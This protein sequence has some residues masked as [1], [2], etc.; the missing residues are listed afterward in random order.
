M[1][2]AI[3]AGNTNT[4]FAVYDQNDEL[5]KVWRLATSSSRTSDEYLALLY[6]LLSQAD[7][8][9]DDITIAILSSVVPDANINIRKFCK[10]HVGCEMITVDPHTV[11]IEI[12]LDKPE[13]VGADR[14][15]NAVAVNHR[16]SRPCIVIDFG[17]ATT[18]DVIDQQGSYCG[19]II[20]PGVNLSMSALHQAAARLPR[21]SVKK[22]GQVIGKDTVSAMQSGMYWGYI[23]MI[24]GLLRRMQDEMGLEDT[25]VVA[26]G[27]L[28]KLFAPAIPAINEVD[29]DLTLF[30]LQKIYINNYADKNVTKIHSA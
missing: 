22:P 15:V 24:E 27:G 6:P 23:S 7:V 28:A 14:L 20:A 5:I 21:V 26:T 1:L 16:Y 11:G 10:H 17:T 30:G 2:L 13:D 25:F 4:V 12:K 3:D 9:I 29:E 8:S 18:F 19:G